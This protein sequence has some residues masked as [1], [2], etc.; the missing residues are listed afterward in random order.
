MPAKR[1]SRKTKPVKAGRSSKKPATKLDLYAKHKTEY[2][3]GRLPA[4]VKVGP[5]TYLSV[6]GRSQPGDAVFQNAV[7]ALYTVAFT[8]KMAHKVAGTDYMVTKLEGQYWLDD[9]EPMPR[10]GDT[11]VWNWQLMLRVPTFITEQKRASTVDDL[12]AKGKPADVRKVQLVELTEGPCVQ[13]LHLGPYTE[14]KASIDKMR[15]FASQ[16]GKS[17]SGRHHEIYVSDP[18]RVAPDKLRTILRQPVA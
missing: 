12:V 10:P 6:S 8:L 17:F 18:R 11:G 3:A 5:A 2:V 4:L 15:A 13:I 14:E 16:L 9:G 1:A 7:G